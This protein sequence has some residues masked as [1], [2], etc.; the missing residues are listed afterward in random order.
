MAFG[1]QLREWRRQRFLTQKE[2]AAHL[3]VTWQTVSRWEAG[4]G[5][6]YPRTQ[7]RL[8]EVLQVEPTEFLD[9]L[10]DAEEQRSKEAA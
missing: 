2:L 6:P 1:E 4:Q 7:R 9:A 3:G 5:I 8:V 10:K